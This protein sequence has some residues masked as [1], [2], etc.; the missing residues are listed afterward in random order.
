MVWTA[1]IDEA[2]VGDVL[3]FRWVGS[4]TVW[5]L[6][7]RKCIFKQGSSNELSGSD[8]SL[9]FNPP[10]FIEFEYTLTEPGTLHFADSVSSNCQNGMIFTVKVASS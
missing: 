5:N 9:G 6:G 7:S 10:T 2:I 8:N 3:V 1:D 4:H